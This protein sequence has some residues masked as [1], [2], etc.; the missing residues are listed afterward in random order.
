[1]ARMAH[2]ICIGHVSQQLFEPVA[3]VAS[4]VV[5]AMVSRE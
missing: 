4:L 5:S 3:S 2:N 1:M